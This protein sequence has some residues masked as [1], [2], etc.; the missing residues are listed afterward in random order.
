MS[1]P[2]LRRELMADV[3]LPLPSPTQRPRPITS[4]V[5]APLG[6]HPRKR[7]RLRATASVPP[8]EDNGRRLDELLD[9]FLDMSSRPGSCASTPNTSSPKVTSTFS[10]VSSG[11]TARQPMTEQKNLNGVVPVAATRSL[12]MKSSSTYLTNRRAA[13]AADLHETPVPG[14]R[15]RRPLVESPVVRSSPRRAV[16]MHPPA[17][18]SPLRAP[19]AGSISLRAL[20]PRLS[21]HQPMRTA[22][23]PKHENRR[24]PVSA[25][26]PPAPA[27]PPLEPQPSSDGDTSIDS[28][29][30]MFECGG[31]EVEQ[32]F[33]AID[34]GR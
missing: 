16:Q 5:S 31:D 11:R 9:R 12:P 20:P 4:S 13:S 8:S 1:F 24:P 21:G 22:V 28:L 26:A 10:S 6:T 34:G 19:Q 32:L 17:A 25:P 33:R 30:M 18:A 23:A 27:P 15:S 29:D 2:L 3:P 7:T 14:A